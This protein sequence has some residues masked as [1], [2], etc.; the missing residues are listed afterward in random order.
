MNG[1]SQ[2]AVMGMVAAFSWLIAL[3]ASIFALE[4]EDYLRCD[5]NSDLC[6]SRV[7]LAGLPALALRNRRTLKPFIGIEPVAIA[8]R[9]R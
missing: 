4:R 6:K 2:S 5:L 7:R 8:V 3:F 9:A 1:V